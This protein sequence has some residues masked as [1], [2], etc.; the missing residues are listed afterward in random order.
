MLFPTTSRRTDHHDVRIDNK[1]E[2]RD[3]WKL[4]TNI[5]EITFKGIDVFTGDAYIYRRQMGI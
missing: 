1:Q 4:I 5:R 2:L 3:F